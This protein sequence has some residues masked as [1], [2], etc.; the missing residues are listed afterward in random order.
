MNAESSKVHKLEVVQENSSLEDGVSEQ[1]SA[2]VQEDAETQRDMSKVAMIVSL[3]VVV[4]L[5]IFFF[6]MNKN[7]AGLTDEIKS[8]GALRE[9]VSSLDQRMVQMRQETPFQ[10]KR[11]IAHDLV[12]EMAMQAAYLGKTLENKDQ[13]DK[14]IQVFGLLKGV[15]EELEQ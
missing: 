8:L 11:M 5:V 14:M 4:L 2:S 6:G 7:I 9:D 12:N 15:R 13:R 10:I 3:L 1:E